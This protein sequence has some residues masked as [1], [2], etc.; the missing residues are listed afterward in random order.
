MEDRQGKGTIKMMSRRNTANS[1]TKNKN[2]GAK[3]H[4]SQKR[5]AQ[6]SND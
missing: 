4:N 1:M 5:T 3:I 6:K 2:T